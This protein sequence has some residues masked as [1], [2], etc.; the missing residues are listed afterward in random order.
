[1]TRS[2]MR[3]AHASIPHESASAAPG[4]DAVIWVLVVVSLYCYIYNPYFTALRVGSSKIVAV[5]VLAFAVLDPTCLRRLLLLRRELV[6][7]IV[8]LTVISMAALTHQT[9][10]AGASYLNQIRV[11]ATW[12]AECIAVPLLFVSIAKRHFLRTRYDTWLCIVACTA[13]VI[14]IVLFLNPPLFDLASRVFVLDDGSDGY[15]VND[16]LIRG[17]GVAS[18]LRGDFA[19]TQALATGTALYLSTRHLGW[20]L[21]IPILA[22][23]VAINA[24]TALFAIPVALVVPGLPVRFRLGAAIVA[25]VAIALGVGL[26]RRTADSDGML[27]PTAN[28][29]VSGGEK[30]LDE[31]QSGASSG[32]FEVLF[33]ESDFLPISIREWALGTGRPSPP[34]RADRVDN[35]YHYTL[36]YGGW[37]VLGAQ[38]AVNLLL[39]GRMLKGAPDPYLPVLFFLLLFAFNVK[40]SYLCAPNSM[41]RVIGITYAATLL[42][43]SAG[44]TPFRRRPTAT[45]ALIADTA[46]DDLLSPG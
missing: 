34:S 19:M 11:T 22:T 5:L 17:F 38:I 7:T 44:S 9:A 45:R 39:F 27:A 20:T 15:R 46:A 14:S 23:S 36:W 41:T 42:L 32:T 13:A 18:G 1:M 30:A 40:W 28:W 21:A 10:E 31:F 6:A 35:G 8:L 29:I 12:F 33:R 37:V 43:P 4:R 2:N 25:F 26:I 24:R 16:Q 3:K